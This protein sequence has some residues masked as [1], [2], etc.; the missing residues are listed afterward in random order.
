MPA[1][2]DPSAGPPEIDKAR[3]ALIFIEFQNEWVAP[4]GTLRKL[5]VEDEAQFQTA[6]DNGARVLEAARQAGWT[7]AHTPLDLRKDSSYRIFGPPDEALGL[8]RAIQKAGT[9]TG[10]GA[11]FPAPF[12]PQVD[13]FVA[14]G[15]S[16]A[17]VL[18]NST[19]DAFLR[20]NDVNTVVFLGFA[21]HV[22][23]ESSLRQAHDLGYN[24]YVVTDAVGA[25]E[26]HQNTY[27][28]EHVLHHFGAG[29][30]SDALIAV[31]EE[32]RS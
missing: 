6:I 12:A 17:S 26:D 13:E 32:A 24:A 10:D 3:T 21:T 18:T 2:A 9:W 23:V 14:A 25:F 15:R 19:L 4:M 29:I 16:G 1:S 31:I 8:R 11:A 27:F 30:T 22:C 20:N 28:Q 7:V 5:L